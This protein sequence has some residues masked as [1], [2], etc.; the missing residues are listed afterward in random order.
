MTVKL[1]RF[2]ITALFGL[3]TFAAGCAAKDVDISHRG[4]IRGE[5]TVQGDRTTS[6]SSTEQG[7]RSSGS[8]SGSVSGSGSASG[9]GSGS[10]SGSGSASGSMTER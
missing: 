2:V 10:V 6:E 8:T 9:S 5:A 7:K 3:A 4:P 1:N